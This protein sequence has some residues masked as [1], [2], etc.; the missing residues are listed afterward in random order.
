MQLG[1]LLPLLKQSLLL[2]YSSEPG[3]PDGLTGSKQKMAQKVYAILDSPSMLYR[4]QVAAIM[5]GMVFK[6]MFDAIGRQ[7]HTLFGGKDGVIAQYHFSLETLGSMITKIESGGR[8]RPRAIPSESVFGGVQACTRLIGNEK[9][10]AECNRHIVSHVTCLKDQLESHFKRVERVHYKGA[11]IA[12]EEWIAHRASGKFVLVPTNRALAAAR[13][14]PREYDVLTPDDKEFLQWPKHM[15][16]LLAKN[17]PLR[18]QLDLF[19]R[20][21][22]NPLTGKPQP[23]RH[24]EELS[25]HITAFCKYMLAASSWMESR[26]SVGSNAI[27]TRPNFTTGAMSGLVRSRSNRMATDYI[28]VVPFSAVDPAWEEGDPVP[29]LSEK[30]LKKINEASRQQVNRARDFTQ[31]WE[32]LKPQ[33]LRLQKQMRPMYTCDFVSSFHRQIAVEG[34][35]SDSDE[36]PLLQL[37]APVARR[38]RRTR[39]R[40]AASAAPAEEAEGGSAD[41]SDEDSDDGDGVPLSLLATDS[42]SL[43]SPAS[44]RMW[45][46]DESVAQHDEYGQKIPDPHP[47]AVRNSAFVY[48]GERGE[49]VELNK[50]L[51]NPPKYTTAAS[52]HDCSDL[53]GFEFYTQMRVYDVD[54]IAQDFDLTAPGTAACMIRYGEHEDGEDKLQHADILCIYLPPADSEGLRIPHI[55]HGYLWDWEDLTEDPDCDSFVECCDKPLKSNEV[56]NSVHIYNSPAEYVE[57]PINIYRSETKLAGVKDEFFWTRVIDL[58]SGTECAEAD[59]LKPL[60]LDA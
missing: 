27:S 46:K 35:D 26:F 11:D 17:G 14:L 9:D 60:R 37:T 3:D 1:P 32:R 4:M 36:M 10:L 53:A 56:V 13:D 52:H 28:P 33:A 23:L 51:K 54:G 42:H 12:E 19:S 40:P 5:M 20:G 48:K 7:N 21:T 39:V 8:T 24:W 25:R 30:N 22:V 2:T 38:R 55:E 16:T 57:F 15:H 49:I 6:P 31:D 58:T 43:P 50:K 47:L 45:R 34:S 41:I 59:I 29:E 18:A 44:Q